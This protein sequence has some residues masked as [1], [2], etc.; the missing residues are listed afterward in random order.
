MIIGLDWRVKVLAF[1][2]SVLLLAGCG[3][4][5]TDASRS[6][7]KSGSKGLEFTGDQGKIVVDGSGKALPRNFPSDLPIFKPSRVKST[8]VS[9]GTSETTM[10]MVIFKTGADTAEVFNFY[11]S[12]LPAAGWTIDSTV[13]GEPGAAIVT[14]TKADQIGSV[15][16]GRDRETKATIISVSVTS[17]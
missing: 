1:L 11:Q 5:S 15:S 10:T 8:V 13:G 4:S 2:V 7:A 6:K 16:I 9:R 12:G 17:K 14:A 3:L